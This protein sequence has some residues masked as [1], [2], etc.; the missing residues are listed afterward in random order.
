MIYFLVTKNLFEDVSQAVF[1]GSAPADTL[2]RQA[3]EHHFPQILV[4]DDFDFVRLVGKSPAASGGVV[5]SQGSA[6]RA[7]C[8]RGGMPLRE[9]APAFSGSSCCGNVRLFSGNAWCIFRTASTRSREA[10]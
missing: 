10:S 8:L 2:V 9:F 4:R 3:V 1:V 7:G 5:S 6:L